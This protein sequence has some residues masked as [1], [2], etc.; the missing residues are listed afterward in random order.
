[1]RRRM[2][3]YA[4]ALA[5]G[6]VSLLGACTT[7]PATSSATTPGTTTPPS[8]T[9]ASSTSS[10]SVPSAQSADGAVAFVS[11]FL[12]RANEAF[13]TLDSQTIAQLSLPQ[14]KT[15][16]SMIQQI[17]TYKAA[18]QRF[19]G[20]FARPTFV[21]INKFEGTS[22]QVLVENDSPGG[23]VVDEAGRTVEQ[24]PPDRGKVIISITYG[25][26]GWQVLGVQGTS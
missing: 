15:C 23:K 4:A 25:P 18:N 11:F 24:L 7:P 14:C 16:A 22:A 5:L 10:P 1:M 21:T 12:G 6:A 8:Q 19:A 9:S 17:A 26:S 3:G 2:K 20:E 13:N